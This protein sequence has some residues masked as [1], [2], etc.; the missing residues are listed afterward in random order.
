MLPIGK[1][2]ARSLQIM[3]SNLIELVSLKV[4]L[5]A[6]FDFTSRDRETDYDR[7]CKRARY[8]GISHELNHLLPFET[9]ML[10]ITINAKATSDIKNQSCKEAYCSLTHV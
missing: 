4:G 2:S 8:A 7:K 3:Y 5:Y 6:Q 9:L 1:E 10:Q